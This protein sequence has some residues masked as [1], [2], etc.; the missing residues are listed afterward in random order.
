MR[1]L[2]L[3]DIQNDFM[4][5]GS[6]P[7][8]HGDEVVAVANALMDSVDFVV[9]TQDWHPQTHGSFASNHY[10]RA[11]GDI[12][13]LGGVSQV[14]W[15]DHCVQGLPGA[16]FHAALNVA[17][18]DAVVRKGTDPLIDSYSGFFDNGHRQD[19]GLTDLLRSRGV[20][21]LVV[22]GLATDYC[23]KYT[24]LD[25][26]TEGFDVVVIEDGVRAVDLSAG[27]GEKAL[28]EMRE[29]GCRVEHLRDLL[30]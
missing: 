29:A 18:I 7:V 25:G 2:L 30:G 4:P 15:P 24:A 27:D 26:E 11:Q 13:T 12:V 23:V 5:F 20:T 16:S 14:L 3:V 21:E 1:A 19:T 9:A 28:A 10:G 22:V 8:P 6:L 17:R